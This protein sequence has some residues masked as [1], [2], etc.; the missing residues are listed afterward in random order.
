MAAADSGEVSE[1]VGI[2]GLALLSGPPNTRKIRRPGTDL[3]RIASRHHAIDLVEVVQVVHCPS[4]E[5]LAQ[6]HETK[7]RVRAGEIQ[8]RASESQAS[9]ILEIARA[10]PCKFIQQIDDRLSL[11]LSELCEAVEGR[12]CDG[13]PVL[14]NDVH[15]RHPIGL[16]AVDE[17]SNAIERT[18]VLGIILAVNPRLRQVPE[19]VVQD[20]RRARKN[21]DALGKESFAHMRRISIGGGR[22]AD[23]KGLRPPGQR[24]LYI[25][26]RAV[27]LPKESI[28]PASI[29]CDS[30]YRSHRRIRRSGRVRAPLCPRIA[31]SEDEDS[32]AGYC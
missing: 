12:E 2:A 14:E 4:R 7:G 18:P 11:A 32:S 16:F 21:R 13:G 26:S 1:P 29:V 24:S 30:S 15:T 9:K 5:K 28:S 22:R 31:L 20:F 3:R 23:G 19:L 17:V 10:K 6:C 25:H 27:Y 8:L